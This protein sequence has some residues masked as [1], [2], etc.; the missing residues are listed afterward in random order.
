VAKMASPGVDAGPI[1]GI[2]RRAFVPSA[3]EECLQEAANPF[4]TAGALLLELRQKFGHGLA[5]AYY[6]DMVRPR[7]LGTSPIGGTTDQRC[8]IHVLTSAHDWLNL[9]W[10]LKSFYA[11]S[12]RRY[13]LCIHDDGTLA[14]EHL[15][16]FSIH[17][18]AARII[19]R[20]GAD[21]V[22]LPALEP[23][24]RCLQFRR[25]NHLAPKIFDFAHFLQSERMLLLDSDV[26][27]YREP[28]E[29]LR[30]IET[31]N[32]SNNSVNA[33][34]ASAYAVNPSV[35]Q[36]HSGLDLTERFN[37]GLGLIHKK[38]MRFDWVEEFLGLPGILEGHF[39]RIEQTIYALCSSRFGVELLPPD[40]AVRLG[41]GIN[42]SPCRHYVGAIR[43]LFYKE[44]I[45]Q[46]VR[47][48]FL[49]KSSA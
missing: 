1:P 30:R 49:D 23:Y 17:F 12:G 31:P 32:Y 4:V 45:R 5:V 40:Y 10:A 29:L 9:I 34:I 39:W 15:E 37:S 8:E 27:F 47:N 36:A 20:A 35:V 33:D 48:R 3:F 21:A 22:M 7:I 38:S 11:A 16:A 46:L 19:S 13:A 25:A 41:D 28:L 24:A 2:I 6:R 14:A 26:L 18:P 44:G 42:G 43:H